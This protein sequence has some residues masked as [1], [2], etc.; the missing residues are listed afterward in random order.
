M[1]SSPPTLHAF[2]D[3]SGQRSK[4]KASSDHFVM[5]A[6][7][8]GDEDLPTSAAVLDQLRTALGR[9]PGDALHWNQIKAHSQRLH[10][11]KTLGAQPW[12]TASSVVVAKR[13]LDGGDM[14]DDQV[15]CYTLRYLLERLSWF[16]RSQGRVLDYT[17]AHVVRFKLATLREYE[18]KLRSS[19]GC[20][21]DWAYLDPSGGKLNQPGTLEQLQLADA[22][23]S[24]TAAAFNV[25]S[26]GNTETRYL[27]ELAPRLY[28]RGNA[29]LTSYGLKM[30][31]WRDS[32]KAAY[33]WAAAL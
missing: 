19:Y 14:N 29:P 2:I 7:I 27:T 31:P 5:S 3:E 21:I 23:A 25:D 13:H 20:Q 9:R 12:L 4:S 6:V 11:A 30:H 26:F 33:P 1:A 16:A 17:L 15:Y 28:R 22:V 32:T 10:L 8:I 18:A 24:A